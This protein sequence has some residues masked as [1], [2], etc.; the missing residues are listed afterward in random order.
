[1]NP[2]RSG[3][4]QRKTDFGVMY[5]YWDAADGLWSP[6]R[7]SPWEAYAVRRVFS[8]HQ[9]HVFKWRGIKK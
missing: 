6:L 5:A 3:V 1:M 2:V 7:C 9:R 4:Y 8:Y